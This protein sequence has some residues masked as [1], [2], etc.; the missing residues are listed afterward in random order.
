MRIYPADYVGCCLAC[1][2]EIRPEWP[3]HECPDVNTIVD[4]AN[5][6]Y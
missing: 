3:A 1:G 4:T 6:H 2:G 5:R